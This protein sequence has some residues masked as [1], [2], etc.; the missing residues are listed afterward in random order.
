MIKLLKKYWAVIIFVLSFVLDSQYGI[1]EK[2]IADIFWLNIVKGLGTLLLAYITGKGGV[3]IFAKDGDTDTDI[4]GGGI[5]N[6]K[7]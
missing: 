3:S 2:L 6:P 7:P 5:K 1:L 4:G